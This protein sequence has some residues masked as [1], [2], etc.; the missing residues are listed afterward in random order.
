MEIAAR[1]RRRPEMVVGR[2]HGAAVAAAGAV[3]AVVIAVVIELIGQFVP[4]A[5]RYQPETPQDLQ[6]P[7]GRRRLWQ[8]RVRRSTPPRWRSRRYRANSSNAAARRPNR[9]S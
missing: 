4:S 6:Y 1:R 8:A 3:I 7:L 5:W 2:G 9:R